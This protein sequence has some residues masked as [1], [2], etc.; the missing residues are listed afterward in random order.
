MINEILEYK[1]LFQCTYVQVIFPQ[2]RRKGN[3][4]SRKA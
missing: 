2:V 1:I 3:E 4:F